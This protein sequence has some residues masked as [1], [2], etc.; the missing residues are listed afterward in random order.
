MTATAGSV[1]IFAIVLNEL[2]FLG[3]VN[4]VVKFEC[5]VWNWRCLRR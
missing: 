3:F 4:V 5:L 1:E 2:C